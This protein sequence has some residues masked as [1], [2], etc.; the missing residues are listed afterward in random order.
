MLPP[1][2]CH[3]IA[4]LA[5]NPQIWRR[6]INN[7]KPAIEHLP[8]SNW[9]FAGLT[10]Q[11][12]F[13]GWLYYHHGWLH[14]ASF[15]GSY[16]IVSVF[17]I[18]WIFPQN[19]VIFERMASLRFDLMGKRKICS[20]SYQTTCSHREIVFHTKEIIVIIPKKYLFSLQGRNIDRIGPEPRCWPR[21]NVGLKNK[22]GRIELNERSFYIL[23]KLQ[24][25]QQTNW[26]CFGFTESLHMQWAKFTWSPYCIL[27]CCIDTTHGA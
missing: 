19:S 1:A 27:Q 7:L 16:V 6:K 23:H 20:C 25:T 11:P 24:S 13:N 9:L 26:K 22:Q 18:L 12:A 14:D 3:I 10:Q 15:H 8:L 2:T 17:T 5:L 4:S 21:C